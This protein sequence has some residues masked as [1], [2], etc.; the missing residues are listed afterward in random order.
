[1]QRG[2]RWRKENNSFFSFPLSPP[3]FRTL[4]AK[5]SI[6]RG[7]GGKKERENLMGGQRRGGKDG[8]VGGGGYGRETGVVPKS[9]PIITFLLCGEKKQGWVYYG[10]TEG[11]YNISDIFILLL[12]ISALEA[13]SSHRD[14]RVIQFSSPKTSPA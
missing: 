6:M 7:G 2:M 5:P 13:S 11:K 10:R 12:L 14:L 1:M 9:L 8:G 4:L 3:L